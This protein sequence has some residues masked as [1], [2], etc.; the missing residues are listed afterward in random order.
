MNRILALIAL[1]LFAAALVS[2]CAVAEPEDQPTKIGFSHLPRSEWAVSLFESVAETFS[3]D[4]GYSLLSSVPL[5]EYDQLESMLEF[6]DIGVECIIIS[7]RHTSPEYIPFQEAKDA[8]IPIILID[9]V[10]LE[11]ANES[12][13]ATIITH[14]FERQGRMAVEWLDEQGLEGDIN[15]LH[16]QGHLDSRVQNGR[17]RGIIGAI[18]ERPNFNLL[19]SRPAGFIRMEAEEVMGIFIDEHEQFDVIIA[20]GGDMAMG[21]I[22]ALKEAD[23][24]PADIIIISMDGFTFSEEIKAILDGDLNASVQANPKFGPYIEDV[25][26]K[27]RRG[28][29]VDKIIYVTDKVFDISNAADFLEP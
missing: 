16:I 25:F 22:D 17:S 6:I 8:G 18:S 10:C 4:N 2:C 14:D 15:I 21:A 19:G 24:D 27:L 5:T 26:L 11:G 1:A 29:A 23:I 9:G 28:E 13:Y 3:N 7:P 20:E 12:M